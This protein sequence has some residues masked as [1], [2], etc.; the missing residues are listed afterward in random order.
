[1]SIA[2]KI[3]QALNFDG[4]G[5]QIDFGTNANLLPDAWTF[6]AWVKCADTATSTL[7]SFG[8]SYPAVK[9]QQNNKGKPIIYMGANNFRYFQES[10]W[11]TLKDGQWHFVA[12]G[13]PGKQQMDIQ[14]ARCIWTVFRW[15]KVR[16]WPPGPQ[17]IKTRL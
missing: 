1:M 13:I 14:N 16:S 9:L 17:Q 5:D 6:A 8:G 3:G 15:R 11:T 4:T 2:G 12:F 10:A 7:I